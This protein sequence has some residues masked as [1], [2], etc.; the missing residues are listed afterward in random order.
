METGN[1]PVTIR[2]PFGLGA[3]EWAEGLEKYAKNYQKLDGADNYN[4]KK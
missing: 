1:G 4:I 2:T 3:E